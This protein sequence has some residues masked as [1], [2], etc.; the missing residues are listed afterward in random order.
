MTKANLKAQFDEIV[1]K[2]TNAE[3]DKDPGMADKLKLYALYKQATVG[4][5]KGDCPTDFT[6]KMKHQAWSKLKGMKKE[7]A[8]KKYIDYFS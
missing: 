3:V 7:D 5:A 4:D 2:V 8:M 6:A 1:E